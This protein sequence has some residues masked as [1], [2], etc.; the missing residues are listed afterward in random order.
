MAG[1]AVTLRRC[2]CACIAPVLLFPM[3]LL[4]YETEFVAAP[5]ARSIA[6]A[7]APA[8]P[9][10]RLQLFSFQLQSVRDTR[11]ADAAHGRWFRTGMAIAKRILATPAA[12]PSGP[13]L[14][15]QLAAHIEIQHAE[16][17][18]FDVGAAPGDRSLS[19][20]LN[21]VLALAP[22]AQTMACACDPPWIGPECSQLDVLPRSRQQPLPAYEPSTSGASW[23]GNA[24]RRDDGTG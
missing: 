18:R 24:L 17:G 9:G 21:G 8:V 14:E 5:A 20:S 13:G 6:H 1:W 22:A 15:R 19:C 11:L 7:V 12:D 3:L 2:L 10:S 23:G 4:V 16:H